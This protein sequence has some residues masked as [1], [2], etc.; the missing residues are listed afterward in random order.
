M[1]RAPGASLLLVILAACAGA[2]CAGADRGVVGPNE[3]RCLDAPS[4]PWPV[5]GLIPD[6]LRAVEAA[7]GSP[8]RYF[9]V[10]ADSRRV[11]VIVAVDDATAA[12]QA[13]YCGAAGFAP[14]EPVGPANG[15]TFAADAVRFDPETVFDRLRAELDDPTILDFAVQG[16][17]SGAVVFDATVVSESGGIL[18]VL[19]GPNGQILGA[20][21]Q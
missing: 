6:A 20:Q 4:S 5:V 14:P 15:S 18:L 16:A 17:A 1:S 3:A 9:E 7:Y 2:A 12:E 21:G 10:S 11:G 13:F 19:L 8:Q